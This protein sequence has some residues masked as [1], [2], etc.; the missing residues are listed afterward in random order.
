MTQD[1]F[2][3]KIPA[4]ALAALTLGGCALKSTPHVAESPWVEA[5]PWPEL[6]D[7]PVAPPNMGEAVAG[8]AAQT[9]AEDAQQEEPG[10]SP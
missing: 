8:A 5:A 6:V 10:E 4:L 9:R 3:R 7:A 1:G 2:S